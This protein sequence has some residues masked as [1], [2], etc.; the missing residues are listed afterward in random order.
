VHAIAVDGHGPAAAATSYGELLAREAPLDVAVV[1]LGSGGEI[2]AVTPGSDAARSAEMVVA[3]EADAAAEPR[4]P[5]VTLS[6]AGL[7]TAR[8]V[9][10]IATGAARAAA[11]A[12]ALREP[13]DVVQRPA[14]ALL[15]SSDATWIVDR[16][17][18]DVLMQDA[19]PLAPNATGSSRP[20]SQ[21]EGAQ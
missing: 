15:P 2:A 1:E 8:H 10:V 5:R 7:R 19:R 13:V 14:Q 20:L 4:V 17:A 21:G 16:A 3:V 12:A 18:A 11:V 6:L 9:V